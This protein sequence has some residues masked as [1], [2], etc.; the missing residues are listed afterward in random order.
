M[1]RD[2]GPSRW[3]SWRGSGTTPNPGR[4]SAA[5]G[6][7]PPAHLAARR[8]GGL[9][10]RP[11]RPAGLRRAR[12]RRRRRQGRLAAPRRRPLPAPGRARGPRG[13]ADG[14]R[15]P[16]LPGAGGPPR[17][18]RRLAAG[19]GDPRSG[20]RA[21]G[22]SAPSRRYGPGWPSGWGPPTPPARAPD[23]R[24]RRRGSTS[25]CSASWP[26][27]SRRRDPDPGSTAD[28][29]GVRRAAIERALGHYDSALASRPG[30]F[31]AHYRAASACFG[32]GRT[33][34]GRASPGGSP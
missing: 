32:L 34:R 22:R 3:A 27:A 33:V 23:R 28:P 9:R 2:F 24:R 20:R 14:A 30:S 19:A 21:A 31:W 18:A 8:P 15:L 25:T 6:T 13:L 5:S 11:P 26:S 12:V 10:D 1:L 7:P 17:L 16:V 29:D 4:S